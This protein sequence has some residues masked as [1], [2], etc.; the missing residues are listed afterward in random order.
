[1]ELDCPVH[2]VKRESSGAVGRGS[3]ETRRTFDERESGDRQKEIDVPATT[4]RPGSSRIDADEDASRSARKRRAVLEAATA[5][6]LRD[7]YLGA[8]MDEIAA[9]SEVSKQ[10]VYKHFTSKEALFVEIVSSM[11]DAAG[12]QVHRAPALPSSRA[13]LPA[14]LEDYALRQLTVVLT[15]RIMQLRRLVISEVARFP[16][17]ARVLYDRGPMRAIGILTGMIDQ[18]S[19]KGLLKAKDPARAAVHFNWLVMADPLNRAMLLGDAGIPKPAA[20]RR[21]A[22]EGVRVFLAAYGA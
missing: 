10:T 5:I 2:F 19:A 20:L 4:S 1:M 18:L 14:F 9:M 22:A 13:A 11:T 15:P 16:E 6:F 17:L 21:E 7:G 3:S 8:S 12:D